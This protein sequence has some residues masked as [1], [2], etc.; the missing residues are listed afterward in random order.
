[1]FVIGVGTVALAWIG[2]GFWAAFSHIHGIV[3]TLIGGGLILLSRRHRPRVD[4][5]N[6]LV[7]FVGYPEGRLFAIVDTPG[8]ADQALA[9][10]RAAQ[11]QVRQVYR[12]NVGAAELDSEG[13]MHGIEG[14]VERSIEHL[15]ADRDDL[16][17]Y[18]DA[19]RQGKIV[20]AVEGAAPSRRQEAER[21]LWNHGAHD[22]EYFGALTVQDLPE[23]QRQPD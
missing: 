9:G 8:Q 12:G 13:T 4:V 22:I 5:G 21:I 7:P 1:M 20:I 6:G 23:R 16:G 19:V 14:E 3:L 11:I 10:L 15:L 18:D 17:N 2:W